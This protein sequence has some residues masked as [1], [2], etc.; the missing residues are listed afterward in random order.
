VRGLDAEGNPY[1]GRYGAWDHWVY[2]HAPGTDAKSMLA[3]YR[4]EGP[5]GY[6]M[7]TT[8]V[9]KDGYVIPAVDYI[10]AINDP[11]SEISR[12]K[13]TFM[14]EAGGQME[15]DVLEGY[16]RA[17]AGAKAA[18]L[19]EIPDWLA[20]APP[21][22]AILREHEVLA[23]GEPGSGVDVWPD[24]LASTLGDGQDE[25][26]RRYS[27]DGGLLAQTE[28]GQPWWLLNFTG[29]AGVLEGLGGEDNVRYFA[30]EQ[31]VVF[32]DKETRKVLA[33]YSIYGEK[34]PEGT[35]FFAGG[36]VDPLSKPLAGGELPWIYEAQ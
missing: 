4:G 10:R 2:E 23:Y 19:P 34:Q 18:W 22:L 11:E 26:W 21:K 27:A 1:A 8:A 31:Y 32:S 25:S 14:L 16:R 13:C 15:P 30:H 6:T 9:D 33:V 24:D 28:P 5:E 29:F 36:W 20:K 17:V 3:W 7:I 35:D 12:S